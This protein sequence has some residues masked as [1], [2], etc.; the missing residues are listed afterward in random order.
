PPWRPSSPAPRWPY[1]WGRPRSA[2]RSTTSRAAS[3]SRSSRPTRPAITR[4]VPPRPSAR[5][6]ESGDD[7]ADLAKF[8]TNTRASPD[9]AL[10]DARDRPFRPLRVGVPRLPPLRG[11]VRAALPVWALARRPGPLPRRRGRARLPPAHPRRGHVRP[12]VRGRLPRPGPHAAAP[13]PVARRLHG[14]ADRRRP[15]RRPL[16]AL[17]LQ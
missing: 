14:G 3:I 13:L 5:R 10:R 4:P 8:A 11:A 17:H 2:L 15:G 1:T 16:R 9:I 12:R 7:D 6:S